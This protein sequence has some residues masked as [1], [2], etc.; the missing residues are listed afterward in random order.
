MAA[1]GAQVPAVVP[2]IREWAPH[3]IDALFGVVQDPTADP[4]ARRK[5]ALKI[6]EFLLPKIAKKAKVLPDEYGFKINPE[7]VGAYR[8]IQLELKAL[9]KEPTRK[10]PANA[11]KIKKL[12]ARSYA[13]R[14]R[15]QQ[16]CPTIYGDKQELADSKRL[17]ELILLREKKTALTEA[18]KAE[19]E[20]LRDRL[21]VYRASPESI[22]RGRRQALG[23]ADRR[24][25]KS[26]LLKD[27]YA[28]A[29]S[30]KERRD[31]K[32]LRRLYPEPKKDLSRLN[33]DDWLE[34]YRDQIFAEEL[35]ASDGNFYPQDSKL[36]PAGAP[37]DLLLEEPKA[38]IYELEKRFGRVELT[39][40]E[41]E[42]LQ[43]L[44]RR[45]PRIAEVVNKMNLEYDFWFE[46]ELKIATKAG[47]DIGAAIEQAKLFCLRFEE[48]GCISKWDLKQLRDDGTWPCDAPPVD[49]CELGHSVC[50]A[51]ASGS[52]NFSPC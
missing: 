37:G 25:R 4:K 34:E 13:I 12:E 23:D 30:R 24:F 43:D 41:E 51:K 9:D 26:R 21:V 7:L 49:S 20:H 44:R 15:F 29:L 52:M 19:K 38:R 8:D 32:F 35:I 47:L 5:A 50:E 39:S 27:F 1:K 10:I 22:A 31:L 14:R 42:E 3:A 28:P 11:Q 6:T 18:Q 36:R 46:R 16:P 2:P 33:G 40:T 17:V 48:S 45:H